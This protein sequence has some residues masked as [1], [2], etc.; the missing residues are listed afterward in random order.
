[1]K[2]NRY[3]EMPLG[4]K[5]MTPQIEDEGSISGSM[6]DPECDDDML[7]NVHTMGLYIDSDEEH[8]KP[9]GL[10]EEIDKAEEYVKHH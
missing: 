2:N 5:T 6:P 7:E 8:P 10:G 9:L 4:D 3:L 1:M